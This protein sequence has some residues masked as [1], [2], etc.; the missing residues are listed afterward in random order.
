MTRSI[1]LRTGLTA[2]ALLLGAALLGAQEQSAQSDGGKQTQGGA[3]KS[4]HA[5]SELRRETGARLRWEPLRSRGVLEKGETRVSFGEERPFLLVNYSRSY[6][7]EP[8]TRGAEGELF[9]SSEAA[10]RLREVLGVRGPGDGSLF[11]STVIIDA[12]HGG[13]DPGAIGRF[14]VD[15]KQVVIMEKNVVLNIARRLDRRLEDRFPEKEIIMTRDD[16]TYLTLEQRT[17]IANRVE[18]EERE[19]MIFLSIHANASLNSKSNGYEV[20]YLPPDYR[21]DLID[22]EDLDQEAR[23]VAPILNT[24][25]EEEYTV[26]SVLLARKILSGMDEQLG[27]AHPNRGLKEES[28]FVVRNAKMPSVLVEVGFVTNRQE[29]MKLRDPAHLKNITEGIYNGVR[30]FIDHFERPITTE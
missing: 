4:M 20:W 16:D 10:E 18:L 21:R 26:E 23:D 19:A 9:F 6:H 15:G 24:M 29:G 7:I 17:E 27:P 30:R 1:L 12:G 25:L 8:P 3:E 5:L 22:P 11:I 13:K 14:T 2:A 28:W